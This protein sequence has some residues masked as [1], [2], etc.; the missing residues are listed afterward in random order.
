MTLSGR[1]IEMTV[2][3]KLT[4]PTTSVT[5]KADGKMTAAY[6]A[7]YVRQGNGRTHIQSGDV[8]RVTRIDEDTS[9]GATGWT[10]PLAS[11]ELAAPVLSFPRLLG[12]MHPYG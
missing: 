7:Y 12:K 5:S 1:F 4:E 6:E 8:P 11:T 2:L 10:L 3:A 9:S